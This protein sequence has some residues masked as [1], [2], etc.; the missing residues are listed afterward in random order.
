[1]DAR[2]EALVRASIDH[3]ARLADL[4]PLEGEH[5]GGQNCPLCREFVGGVNPCTG[6]PIHAVT[7]NGCVGSP[8]RDAS[9]AL[10][11]AEHGLGENAQA[12]ARAACKEELEFLLS[13]LPGGHQ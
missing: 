4:A 5:C 12:F 13:L 1:M 6:C 9:N 2:T 7:S 10:F 8:Y 11:S 3:W